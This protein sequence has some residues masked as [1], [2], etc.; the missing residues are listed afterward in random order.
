[1]IVVQSNGDG[2]HTF[3]AVALPQLSVSGIK[4]EAV[5]LSKVNRCI[6]NSSVS[7]EII[8]FNRID[9]AHES[10][11]ETVQYIIMAT[12]RSATHYHLSPIYSLF[13]VYTEGD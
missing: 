4:A 13:N 5:L 6:P 7:Q 2:P 10:D 11:C 3:I 8:C 9:K 12:R 1:M